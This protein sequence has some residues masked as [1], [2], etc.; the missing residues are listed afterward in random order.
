MKGATVRETV[1]AALLSPAGH[2]ALGD[3]YVGVRFRV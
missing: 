3:F 2:I 1:T